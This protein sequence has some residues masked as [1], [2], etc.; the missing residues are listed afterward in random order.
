MDP[1]KGIKDAERRVYWLDDPRGRSESPRLDGAAETDLLV[2]G[3]GFTGLWTA[4]LAKERDPGRAVTLIEGRRIGWAATGRNGGFCA[5]SLTHGIGNG[6]ARWPGEMPEL[7]RQGLANLDEIE[8]TVARHGIDCDFRR[9][10]EMH[11]ATEAWQVPELA[12]EAAAARSLCG[13]DTIEELDRDRVRAEV[14]S[15]TYLAGLWD[16]RGVAMIDPVRLAW[17]LRDACLSLGVRVHERTPALDL[18]AAGASMAVRTPGG[19]IRARQVALGTGVF[20]PLLRRLRHLVIPVYDYALVTEPIPERLLASVGWRNRQGI[21][22]SANRFHYYRLTHDNRILWGGY[23]A[24]YYNGGLIKGAHNQRDRTFLTLAEHFYQ[25]FPQLDGVRF[26]HRWGGVIDTCSRF[27]AFFGTAYGARVAYAAGYTG[28]GVGASRFGGNVM[29]DLLSG[30]ATERTRLAM[31]RQTPIPFPPE[32]IRSG[33]VQLTRWSIAR[34]DEDQG[35]R[36]LWLR[37]L[38]ALGVGFDS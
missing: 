22:D 21:G 27:S 11:V 13:G 16:R 12:E 15:P 7:Q 19:G 5:A 35:R 29:L 33:V 4:L 23:D 9:S 10:G 37:T 2:I 6:L 38:D 8:R 28:L 14:D 25:T 20:A 32:P 17:G 3:G 26:S 34:A 24:I 31:V 18:R 30:T 1:A 36:N